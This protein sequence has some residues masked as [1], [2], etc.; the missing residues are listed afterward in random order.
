MFFAM[1]VT[2]TV[3]V[4]PYL[5]GTKQIDRI[6]YPTLARAQRIRRY[7]NVNARELEFRRK[8]TEYSNKALE[9]EQKAIEQSRLNVLE[10]QMNH[11]NDLHEW[12]LHFSDST[13]EEDARKAAEAAAERARVQSIR[14]KLAA[15]KREREFLFWQAEEKARIAQFMADQKAAQ[16]LEQQQATELMRSRENDIQA[17]RKYYVP[18]HENQR[19]GY[20]IVNVHG[21]YVRKLPVKA[22]RMLD[23]LTTDAMV[24]VNGWITG[25]EVYGNPIWFKLAHNAG[26]IWSGGVDNKSTSGLMNYN[27]MNEPGD[28]FVQ[29]NA[30]GE[31]VMRH[32]EPSEMK[33]LIDHEIR[34]L[35]AEKESLARKA[36][37]AA[38]PW[39]TINANMITSDKISVDRIAISPSVTSIT[40]NGTTVAQL[41]GLTAPQETQYNIF[42]D[43]GQ[44]TNFWRGTEFEHMG[45]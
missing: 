6:K 20:R 8:N 30:Y 13:A 25:E 7:K 5:N 16:A 34:F 11:T 24:S 2:G 27:Y 36:L 41:G 1:I 12:D 45:R 14:D 17:L 33:N 44:T 15:E 26:W 37:A 40:R 38:N 22:S 35:E 19:F 23:N 32:E 28:S 18:D 4:R 39:G 9:I 21:L 10:T 42:S 43:R 29:K 31:I 3:A